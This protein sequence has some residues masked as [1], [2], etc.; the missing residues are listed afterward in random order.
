MIDGKR[1]LIFGYWSGG[2]EK[3]SPFGMGEKSWKR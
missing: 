2:C 3:A 1:V